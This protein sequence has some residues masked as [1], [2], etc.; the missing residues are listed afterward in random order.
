[1]IE[2]E[3]KRILNELRKM[4]AENEWIE[5]KEAK[6]SY[7]FSKIGKYFSALSNEANLK[8]EA[9]AWLIFGVEDKKRL[10][11]GTDYRRNRASLDSL[12][13]EVAGKTNG[14]ISFI[15]I[16]EVVLSEGRVIMFQIP[17]ASPG[18]PTAWEGHYYGR[19]GE[20]IGPLSLQEIE[21]IR[22]QSRQY[23]WSAQ[24]C[25]NATVADLD[26]KA[27]AKA[28]TEY[29]NK[30][31]KISDDIDSWDD[32][33]F[34]NKIKITVNGQITR[35]A[36]LLLGKEEAD[37]HISPYVA[38]ISW[39]LKDDDNIEKDYEH[40]GAPFLLNA[41]SVLSK[42]RNLKYRYLP[43]NT[44]FPIEIHQ[45][46]AY[47]IREALHNCIA[48]QDYELQGRVIVIE[49]SDELLFVNSGEFI[50]RTVEAV[51][52]QDA[53]Q[54]YYRNKLLTEV[55]VNLNMIDTIGSGI[56]RMFLT[57][58][59]RYFPLPSYDLTNPEM[60]KVLITG[61]VIDPNYTQVLINRTDLSIETV[62][63]LDKV[64]KKE[65]LIDQEYKSLRNQRLVEGRYPNIF[66]SAKIA[67]VTGNKSGYIKNRAFDDEHY[68]K[69]IIAFIKKYQSATRQDIDSLL[70]DKL[71]D[72]L[73]EQQK[74]NKIKNLIHAMSKRDETI[75]N[76]G[77]CKKS[78]WVFA[79]AL[80]K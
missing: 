9:C 74:K 56:K 51:I 48:H 2:A 68:K 37:S 11:V 16:H 40:F 18:I 7:D 5:F 28:R 71:S 70:M 77:S 4:P 62:I 53:P 46:D 19:D 59:K 49:K 39:I 8:R 26:P 73:D 29:K 24:I 14:R 58:R 1:M 15:E 23:D 32:T 63:C 65:K 27:I 50:P 76:I 38:R 64:Q 6:N 75:R 33:T 25:D 41:D 45:Y 66:V 42:I 79:D 54:S 34:L 57:Q 22:N 60:I 36:I 52:S 78:I 21:Q 61:K 10:I 20:S 55:M 47:V 12:K 44:L 72:V 69:M 43:N 13:F 80:K 17:A 67:A 3:L 31:Q 35:A 30:N